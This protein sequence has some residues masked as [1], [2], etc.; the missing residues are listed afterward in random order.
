MNK[1]PRY[2]HILISAV[3]HQSLSQSAQSTLKSSGIYQH[4]DILHSFFMKQCGKYRGIPGSLRDFLGF[5]FFDYQP[6][7]AR[8]S[9]HLRTE[10]YM[11]H[12]D[13][14]TLVETWM[15]QIGHHQFIPFMPQW[16]TC[17]LPQ[18]TYCILNEMLLPQTTQSHVKLKMW[19]RL[20]LLDC[21][22][23][24]KPYMP[25]HVSVVYQGVSHC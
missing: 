17:Y 2:K 1:G 22:G 11:T 20:F 8:H 3:L 19:D 14:A 24:I 9:L 21:G 7:N 6:L 13:G 12:P 15:G 18:V 16:P 10:K 4:A 5:P 23:Y 25:I